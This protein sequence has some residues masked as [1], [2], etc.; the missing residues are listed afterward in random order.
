MYRVIITNLGDET[1]IHEPGASKQL[2][3]ILSSKY[4]EVLSLAEEFS[5]TVP[6]D[7][8]GYNLIEGLMTKV[9]VIDTRDNS[10]V[11]TGRVLDTKDGMGSDGKFTINVVCEGALNYLNDSQTRRW[12]FQNQTP[13]QILTYLLNQH[14]LKVDDNR[15]IQ[16][17]TI[18]IT[19]HI[20]IDT[21]Y[22]TTLN[23]I[24]TKLHNILGGDFKIR[25]TNGTL[26]L[27]YLTSQ[28]VDNGVTIQIGV[29]ASKLI[30]EYDPKDIITRAIPMGY[31]EGI[32]QLNITS[33]NNGVE[34]IEVESKYGVIEGLVTNK[35]I[36]NANT[37]KIYGQTVLNEKKQPKLIIDTSAIDRS[38][39]AQYSMEKYELGD[40]L[41][42]LSS[43]LNID[44]YARVIERERDL[45]NSPWDPTLT[46]STRPITLSDQIIEL[47]Q[48]NM[49]LENCPQGSTYIDTF[50][51][52]ENIDENHSFQLPIW[53]SPDILY[54]NRVRLH[55]D[56]QKYR[57]YEKGLKG[58][59]ATTTSTGPSSKTTSDNGG[60]STQTSSSGGGSTQTSS[61][62]GQS[63]QTSS[64]GGGATVSVK[65]WRATS[66]FDIGPPSE[67]DHQWVEVVPVGSTQ[68]V[69]LFS[70]D[71]QHMIGNHNHD[72]TTPSHQHNV[73][74]P[75]HQHDV[76]IPS[77]SHGMDHNH[78][79]TIP[80]H[81][82]DIEYGIFEDTHPS[83]VQVKINGSVIPDINLSEGGSLDT[84]ISQYVGT[85]GETYNLEVTSSRNGRVN[86]WVS[87]QAF[88]QIK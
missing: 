63:T 41:R 4:K 82:H 2:P 33:V 9:K 32:N 30:R 77:H 50:G 36:Q 28:G 54:V 3:H 31:G 18:Q 5:F 20:T 1:I 24:I 61:S 25:E 85:P 14:N 45:I 59:G 72:V 81:T 71:H 80:D 10:V 86:V 76:T 26:Y 87:V 39:K 73:T 46:I 34:Y 43:I 64:N 75:V 21:N 66:G 84:D 44:V 65:F 62:A 53:L 16:V 88:I 42:I 68:G 12:H 48:R 19:Q 56:S 58:G 6:Y 52:A 49:N 55:I 23:S 8:P 7:N 17:G 78:Q 40:T 13:Q 22:E 27:D 15:K 29:N 83:D 11:F 57:A 60:Q 47:K 67:L 38:V 74:I 37:L 69:D 70:L 35:D 51:Y 79:I